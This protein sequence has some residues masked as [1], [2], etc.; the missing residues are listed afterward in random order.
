M[1]REVTRDDVERAAAAVQSYQ[2]QLVD[3]RSRINSLTRNRRIAY[4]KRRY[5][6][7]VVGTRLFF[8]HHGE[9]KP[10]AAIGVIRRIGF[11]PEDMTS[12]IATSLYNTLHWQNDDFLV[13]YVAVGKSPNHELTK[14]YSKLK[15][16]PWSEVSGFMFERFR[17]F[18]QLKGTHPQWPEFGQQFAHALLHGR[19]QHIEDATPFVLDYIEKGITEQSP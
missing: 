6:Y 17:G 5:L 15:Q 12:D 4:I 11:A 19:L 1:S 18:G 3:V 16:L 10:V 2:S 8:E 9:W 14:R 7:T 13:Q